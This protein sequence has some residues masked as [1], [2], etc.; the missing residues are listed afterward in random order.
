MYNCKTFYLGLFLWFLPT[1]F[2][3]QGSL[4]RGVVVDVEGTPLPGVSVSVKNTTKGSITSIDGKYAITGVNAND[5]VA[6][7]YVGF[8]TQEHL[9]GNQ[10]VLDIIMLESASELEEVTVVAFQKQKK[11]SVIASVSTINP[12]ELKV[13]QSN[14]T[15]ALA[16]KIAGVISYQRSGEP[17]QDN[18]EFFIR[19]VTTFGYGNKPLILIDGLESTTEDLARLE[20]D[21]VE[22]FSIMK[23]ATATA[24]YGARGA[25]GVILVTTKVGKR[26]KMTVS[27]RV[28]TNISTPTKINKFLDGVD[29]MEMYNTAIRMRHPEYP[30]YYSKDK[31]EGTRMGLN[32]ELYPNVDWYHELFKG[33]VQNYRAN[34][35]ASGG[36]DVAQYY[37]SVSYT[38]E[39]GLL[40]VDP[41]NNFNNNIDIDRFNVRANID[42]NLTKT[43]KAALKYYALFDRYNGP[44]SDASGIFTSVMNANPVSF[45]KTYEKPDNFPF[46]KHTL[47]G[48]KGDGRADAV[49][50]YAQMV[51]GYR[52]RFNATNQAQFQVE[53]DLSMITKGL[54][55]RGLV[56]MNVTSSNQITR[57]FVPFYYGMI[58][59]QTDEGVQHELKLLQ[60]GTESLTNEISNGASSS[61]Y[62][63]TAA[64]YNRTFDKH[65]VGGLLV[66]YMR[67]GLNEIAGS[68]VLSSL[69][70]RNMG[71][72][73]RATYGFDK[74]YYVE[75]NFGYNGSEKFEKDKRWGFF[76]SAGLGWTVSNENFYGYDLKQ[77]LSLLKFKVTYGLVGN[78]AIA[79]ASD[80]FFYLSAVNIND[81]GKGYT[82]G[83]MY[84]QSY[85]GYSI[86]RYANNSITWEVAQKANYGVELNFFD[87]LNVQVDYFTEQRNNIY[88]AFEFIPASMGLTAGL[89][90]NIGK[91][92]S[93]GVDVASDFSWSVKKDLWFTARA[94]FT[95]ATNVTLANG[96]PEYK[97]AYLSRI[98]QPINQQWG[99]VAERLFIDEYDRINSPDQFNKRSAEEGGY[100]PGD[101]KYVDVNDDGKIDQNDQVPIG[102]PTVPEII[103]GFGLSSGW[104]N[105]DLSFFFQGSARSSFFL[106]PNKIAPFIGERNAL[107]VITK[108]Y[109]SYENPD[110]Y[111]FWP[112]MATYEVP[113][114]SVPSTWWLQDGSFLRLKSVELGYSLKDNFLRRQG[115]VSARIYFTGNNLFCLSKFKLWDPEMG[116]NG[117]GYP[118]Q[119]VYNIGFQFT[120]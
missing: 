77:V 102:Y 99:Y 92:F 91:A 96:E 60:E 70:V 110:P 37:L 48:N 41:L 87:K 119:R 38:N 50:P 31:I 40:K 24:L 58:E 80:R 98:G 65:D 82:W 15:T 68:N 105:V 52:D 32:P 111:A 13:P 56:S 42:F 45:P 9:V 118:T 7:N 6:F 94:N 12:K 73:G 61:F 108:D 30:L 62:I 18:A 76:P 81:G 49:N 33:Y 100:M 2:L 89:S 120:F 10:Q 97:Y 47:F 101:I 107:E 43:T 25:N 114:N 84:N 63:E 26:G 116:N 39:K 90:N 20:P 28:E 51:N 104:K 78:D 88:R 22:S 93:Q 117:L 74:R 67:E 36:G 14:L 113:N 71:L 27:A 86:N 8:D 64:Q 16:G 11:E 72:S 29:Y 53:Q 34:V 23:D 59:R 21:N 112:R 75:L 35:S 54:N 109:W 66:F 57:R 19:G 83:E 95:Y 3:A 46:V 106:D 79:A 4:V 17:G 115:I 69:P 85:N 55:L 103:Y 1:I 44:A 5:T